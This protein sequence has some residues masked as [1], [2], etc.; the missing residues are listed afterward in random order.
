MHVGGAVERVG[1]IVVRDHAFVTAALYL[2]S[3]EHEAVLRS[4]LEGE[5]LTRDGAARV[6]GPCHAGATAIVVQP[7]DLPR[8]AE[9][10]GTLGVIGDVA[11]VVDEVTVGRASI[12][13]GSIR[14][15]QLTRSLWRSGGRPGCNLSQRRARRERGRRTGRGRQLPLIAATIE[16]ALCGPGSGVASL[17]DEGER[18]IGRAATV[19]AAVDVRFFADSWAR[20][21]IERV[22]IVVERRR[23]LIALSI[24]LVSHDEEAGTVGALVD[25]R[26]TRVRTAI[27]AAPVLAISCTIDELWFNEPC[28]VRDAARVR[29]RTASGRNLARILDQ[30]AVRVAS[31]LE[32]AIRTSDAAHVRS[33]RPRERPGVRTAF[34]ERCRRWSGIGDTCVA[35]T[36]APGAAS[37]SVLGT[38]AT[39]RVSTRSGC[40]DSSCGSPSAARGGGSAVREPV[41]RHTRAAPDGDRN[42]KKTGDGAEEREGAAVWKFRSTLETTSERTRQVWAPPRG[43]QNSRRPSSYPRRRCRASSRHPGSRACIIHQAHVQRMNRPVALG[44]KHVLSGTHWASDTPPQDGGMSTQY[45]DAAVNRAGSPPLLQAV[46]NDDNDKKIRTDERGFILSTMA[47]VTSPGCTWSR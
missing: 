13:E 8:V 12:L 2:I 28:L 40:P 15:G 19:G 16:R 35:K 33:G 44:E 30:V 38:A 24:G 42:R 36:G 25:D 43:A 23:A 27:F 20:D 7:H 34:E 41:A 46:M 39:R 11:S 9:P 17:G 18:K 14:A 10:G 3:N 21:A 22:E 32:R 29:E 26:F 4:G 6:A 1:W 37:S 31:V 47:P 45:A 5:R